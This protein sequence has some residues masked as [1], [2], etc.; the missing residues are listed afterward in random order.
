[1]CIRKN[2]PESRFRKNE[3]KC[4]EKY[5]SDLCCFF[6]FFLDLSILVIMFT[7]QYNEWAMS[8]GEG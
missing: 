1:M 6:F 3:I 4:P 2:F 8:Q 5:G 7:F